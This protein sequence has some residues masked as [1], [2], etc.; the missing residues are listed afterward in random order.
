[1][2]NAEDILRKLKY[3][4]EKR[5]ENKGN[6]PIS[7]DDFKVSVKQYKDSYERGS[8]WGIF[9]RNLKKGFQDNE[10]KKNK[11]RP[12][13]ILNNPD[14]SKNNNRLLVAPGSS[15]VKHSKLV[16][17]AKVDKEKPDKVTHF[18]IFM[19]FYIQQKYFEN[20]WCKLSDS[21]QKSLD[22]IYNPYAKQ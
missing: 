6:K 22:N 7:L 8:V 11:Q 17:F 13:L 15:K 9:G 1:M 21:E 4:S 12:C 18:L 14:C 5:T 16:L 10:E 2:E 19:R 3:L 20:F